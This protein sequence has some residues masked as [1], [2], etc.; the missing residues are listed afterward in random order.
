[1]LRCIGKKESYVAEKC[2]E[3]KN[4]M[5]KSPKLENVDEID[6]IRYGGEV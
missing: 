4:N 1:M 5:L 3:S 2:Q 6:F